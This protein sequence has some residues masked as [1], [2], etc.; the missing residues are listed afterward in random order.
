MSDTAILTEILDLGRDKLKEGEYLK[1]ATFLK[2]LTNSDD[3]IRTA[4]IPLNVKIEY[5]TSSGKLYCITIQEEEMKVFK[6]TRP[7]ETKYSGTQNGV[8]FIM[9]HNEF[10]SRLRRRISF[11]GMKN[12]KRSME[13]GEVEEYRNLDQYKKGLQKRW[14]FEFEDRNDTTHE[15]P[16]DWQDEY[17]LG[18]LC[19]VYE[20][21]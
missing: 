8:P 1:L 6:G 2:T 4:T 12:I 19:G 3:L 9:S 17:V 13:E 10:L 20:F 18:I 14:D 16:E 21:E 7:N 5:E 15:S 11:Y